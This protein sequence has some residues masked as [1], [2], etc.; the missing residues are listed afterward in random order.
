MKKY[1]ITYVGENG[2]YT[3][4]DEKDFKTLPE[5][6]DKIY[7]KGCVIIGATLYMKKC[8]VKIEEI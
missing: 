6:Q 4:A 7:A 8:L 1:R 2:A 3:Y 5:I